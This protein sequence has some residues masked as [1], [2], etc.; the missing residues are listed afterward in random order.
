MKELKDLS[1]KEYG[2]DLAE[3]VT[4]STRDFFK[5]VNSYRQRDDHFDPTSIINDSEG[6]S[7]TDKKAITQRWAEYFQE[8]L[9]PSSHDDHIDKVFHP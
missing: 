5:A 6:K 9:N 2:E 7:L 8:L 4:R 1:W 3:K